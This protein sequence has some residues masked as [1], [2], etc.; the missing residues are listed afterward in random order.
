M[1]SLTSKVAKTISIGILVVA[2]SPLLPVIALA[3][4]TA[5]LCDEPQD[6]DEPQDCPNSNLPVHQQPEFRF[7][8]IA[9]GA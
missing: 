7:A 2:I 1:K 8:G 5:W 6:F 4:V 9:I 3:H